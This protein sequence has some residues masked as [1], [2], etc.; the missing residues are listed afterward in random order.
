MLPSPRPSRPAIRRTSK[1]SAG[2]P[3]ANCT[4][5]VAGPPIFRRAMTKATRMRDAGTPPSSSRR[6]YGGRAARYVRN[7]VGI[8]AALAFGEWLVS[9]PHPLP[10]IPPR[11]LPCPGR[12]LG[13]E[14]EEQEGDGGAPPPFPLPPPPPPT[15]TT[16]RRFSEAG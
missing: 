9:W 10:P 12:S 8:I 13:G 16:P 2:S 6:R 4:T 7:S 5:C 15:T 11:H 3:A 1:R 14:G